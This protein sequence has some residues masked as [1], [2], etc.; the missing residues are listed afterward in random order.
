MVSDSRVMKDKCENL[1]LLEP[2]LHP[3]IQLNV[4]TNHPFINALMSPD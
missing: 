2:A 3:L 4:L 1:W